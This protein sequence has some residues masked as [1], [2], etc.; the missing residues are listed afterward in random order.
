M[1]NLLKKLLEPLKSGGDKKSIKLYEFHNSNYDAYK[2]DGT[3]FRNEVVF[4]MQTGTSISSKILDMLHDNDGEN[5]SELNK[6]FCEYTA[7]F[8]IWKNQTS[9]YVGI[10]HY[11]RCLNFGKPLKEENN[12]MVRVELDKIAKVKKFCLNKNLLKQNCEKFDLILPKK[13]YLSSSLKK[14]YASCHSKEDFAIMEKAI[15][16]LYPDK[17]DIYQ[18]IFDEI[19]YIYVGGLFLTKHSLF[20]ELMEFV[21]PILF[22]CQKHI[23]VLDDPYQARVFAFLGE[24]LLTAFFTY[25]I[26][27]REVNYA[28]KQMIFF[29]Q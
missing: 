12:G 8:Q 29:Y 16:N 28:E 10:S 18:K 17:A 27:E 7:L 9:D 25:L 22:E 5:I 4:P 1:F 24:R 23:K 20:V 19:D 11:R 6:S 21:F 26:K 13:S 14:H 3:I 15:K 2:K